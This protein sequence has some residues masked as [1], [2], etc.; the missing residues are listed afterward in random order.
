MGFF[1]SI[2]DPGG[3][4]ESAGS[5]VS[6]KGDQI[7]DWTE[8]NLLG[9]NAADAAEEAAAAQAARD[10][11]TLDIKDASLTQLAGL[12]G[13]GGDSN[14]QEVAIGRAKESPL[15]SEIMGQLE[16]GQRNIAQNQ[17]V[18]GIRGGNTAG[19]LAEHEMQLENR[20]LLESYNQQLSGLQGLAGMNPTYVSPEAQGITAAA[21][22]KEQGTAAGVDLGSKLAEWYMSSSEGI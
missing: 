11:I 5:W 18:T 1:S 2:V 21:Q 6:E 10:K 3:M 13:I 12:Y 17:S 19:M 20:A 16:T 7:G 8:Q 9:G 22:A 15:Y 14:S 4:L